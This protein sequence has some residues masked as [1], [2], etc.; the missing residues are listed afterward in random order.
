MIVILA[1]TKLTQKHNT[2]A[3]CSKTFLLLRVSTYLVAKK[4]DLKKKK[5]E[6][7]LKD[8]NCQK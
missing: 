8:F 6:I 2:T 3:R 5:E 7:S 1:I 4:W